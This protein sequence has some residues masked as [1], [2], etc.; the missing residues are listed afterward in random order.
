P[1]PALLE[2][3]AAKAAAGD[4]TGLILLSELDAERAAAIAVSLLDATTPGPRTVAAKVLGAPGAT[5]A[6]THLD[7]LRRYRDDPD[8]FVRLEVLEALLGAGE[9]DTLE[10]LRALTQDATDE[11][12]SR[13]ATAALQRSGYLPR[14]DDPGPHGNTW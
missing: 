1:D 4:Y 9:L 8:P 14:Q 5:G 11:R 7:D 6:R 10:Q 3:Y 2:E 13:W 12:V